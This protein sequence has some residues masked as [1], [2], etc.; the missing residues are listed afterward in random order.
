ML[1]FVFLE[2]AARSLI[3]DWEVRARRV[4]AEF[5]A[6]CSTHVTDPALLTLIESLRRQSPEF[7]QFWNRYGVLE[8]EGGERTFNHPL[9]G[10]LRYA[11]VTFNLAGR[12]DLKLTML[13]SGAAGVPSVIPAAPVI[14][15][16]A[17]TH[18]RI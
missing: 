16:Q 14:S 7:A 5:R 13:V 12:P 9:D 10:L 11:Q 15:V 18:P 17:V 3:C 6:G 4:V 2:P 1:H 8:R